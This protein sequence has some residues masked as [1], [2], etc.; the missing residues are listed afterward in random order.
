M[1][2]SSIPL[3]QQPDAFSLPVVARLTKLPNRVVLQWPVTVHSLPGQALLLLRNGI[4]IVCDNQTYLNTELDAFS[5]VTFPDDT[6]ASVRLSL[7]KVDVEFASASEAGYFRAAV[8]D[9]T[10]T[11]PAA[12]QDHGVPLRRSEGTRV[13][14][15]PLNLNEDRVRLP[16]Q[17][18]AIREIG[19]SDLPYWSAASD[20][21]ARLRLEPGETLHWT[22]RCRVRSLR[23]DHWT[24]PDDTILVVTDRRTAFLTTGFDKGGGWAGFGA[25]GLAVALTANAISKRRAANRSAGRVAIGQLRHEWIESVEL[26]KVKALIGLTDTYLDLTVATEAGSAVIE[27]WGRAVANEQFAHWLAGLMAWQRLTLHVEMD[28]EDRATLERLGSNGGAMEAARLSG[29]AKW[30]L[31]GNIQDLISKASARVLESL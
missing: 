30:R 19:D 2:D 28:N 1:T 10:A 12:T 29:S 20:D 16:K 4:A 18:L 31:P 13:G 24:L 3:A 9:R 5:R 15:E 23:P 7:K 14:R 21:G 27:L 22:G 6:H 25:A 8:K 11:V 17:V 26:R